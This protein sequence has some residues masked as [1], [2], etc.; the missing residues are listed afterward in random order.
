MHPFFSILSNKEMSIRLIFWAH[1]DKP[2]LGRPKTKTAG[3]VG[4]CAAVRLKSTWLPHF[5]EVFDEAAQT[6]VGAPGRQVAE[7]G[8]SHFRA[9]TI[10]FSAKAAWGIPSNLAR[11]RSPQSG[12]SLS[13]IPINVLSLRPTFS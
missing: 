6:P 13:A 11:A 7:K 12:S 9:T 4:R 8:N 10:R 5:F 1:L 2:V 3:G